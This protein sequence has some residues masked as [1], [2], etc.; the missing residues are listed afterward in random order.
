[1]VSGVKNCMLLLGI[2]GTS[3]LL[4][5]AV[6]A[7]QTTSRKLLQPFNLG[8]GKGDR[9]KANAGFGREGQLFD[10]ADGAI[11]QQLDREYTI[12]RNSIPYLCLESWLCT[13]LEL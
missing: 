2:L 11:S 9:V 13:V 1:M 7:E 4:V 6:A 5:P 12:L 8:L 3:Y 10:V